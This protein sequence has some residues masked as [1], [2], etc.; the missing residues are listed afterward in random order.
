MRGLRLAEGVWRGGVPSLA[1]SW[2]STFAGSRSAAAAVSE[3]RARADVHIVLKGDG[4]A[5]LIKAHTGRD[6]EVQHAT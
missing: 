5:Y 6:Y 3:R 2:R 1:P 4:Q